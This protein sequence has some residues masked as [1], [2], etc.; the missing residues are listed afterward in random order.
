MAEGDARTT[1][2]L[3]GARLQRLEF[4]LN[5]KADLDGLANPNAKPALDETVSER[6]TKLEDDLKRL[7]SKSHLVQDM[8]RLGRMLS[9]R[10]AL[11]CMSD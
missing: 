11:E 6:L 10:I 1:L 3:L 9:Q 7:T 2:A 8:L 4:L 5:G